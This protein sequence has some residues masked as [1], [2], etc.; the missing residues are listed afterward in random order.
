VHHTWIHGNF[1]I[2]KLLH[3]SFLCPSPSYLYQ[4]QDRTC[5]TFQSLIFFVK[6]KRF[7]CLF[8]IVVNADLLW[9]FHMYSYTYVCVYTYTNMYYVS[10]LLI[11][12][13]IFFPL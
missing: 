5:F 6:K 4:C 1:K 10:N 3:S 7:F 13:I 12:L 9:H 2:F 8:L 11:P